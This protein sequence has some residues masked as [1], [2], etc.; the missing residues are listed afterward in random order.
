MNHIV[1]RG[2][3]LLSTPSMHKSVLVFWNRRVLKKF[4][5]HEFSLH[6]QDQK[7]PLLS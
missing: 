1:L 4:D 5:L 7:K 6:V 2:V 3:L